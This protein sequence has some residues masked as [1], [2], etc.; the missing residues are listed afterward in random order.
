MATP[1][2]FVAGQILT[3]AQ[4]NSVG[5]WLVKSQT[6][7]TAVSS[8]TVTGAFSADYDNYVITVSGGASSTNTTLN[9]RCGTTASGYRWSYVYTSYTNAPSGAGSGSDTSVVYCGFSNTSGINAVINVSGPFLSGPTMI[10]GDGGSIA[11]FAGRVTG[12]EPNNTSFT[13]F[14]LVNGTGT[15]TGGTIRVYGFNN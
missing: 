15:M 2:D 13:S 5:M 14:T 8:V 4:M 10:T 3:A 1:P 9:F 7:G 12:Y 6:I 11:N